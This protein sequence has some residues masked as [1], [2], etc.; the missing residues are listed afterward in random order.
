MAQNGRLN[1]V[2]V[3]HLADL[4][5]EFVRGTADALEPSRLDHGQIRIRDVPEVRRDL[6]LHDVVLHLRATH[7][8]PTFGVAKLQ[9]EDVGNLRCEVLDIGVPVAVVGG[10]KQ[11]FRIVV[12]KNEAHVVDG[13]KLIHERI[14]DAAVQSSKKTAQPVGSSWRHWNDH[15]QLRNL[16]LTAPDPA[17][18]F[19]PS[20]RFRG[21]RAR[22]Y[23]A[24]HVLERFFADV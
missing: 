23:K 12:Q 4:V 8:G 20:S 11:Q 18:G 17:G 15:C 7:S 6:M 14:A 9:V 19:W 16:A 3:D 21:G 1:V 24:Y 2:E 5:E 10:A 13:A 22:P